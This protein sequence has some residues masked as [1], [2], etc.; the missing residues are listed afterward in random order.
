MLNYEPT[1]TLDV[2]T[3]LAFPIGKYDDDKLVNMGLNRWFG[4]IAFPFKYHLGSFSPGYMTS[5]EIIPSVWLF[6]ENDDF[7]GRKLENDPMVQLEGH[8]THDFTPNFYGSLDML[9]RGGFQS[10]IDDVEVGHAIDIGN[11]GFTVNYQATDNLAIRAGYSTNLF[12]D[13]ELDNSLF[14]VQFVYAWHKASE[15]MKKLMS[16]H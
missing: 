5:I 2:A 7:I 16:G 3:M 4:R 15:N 10:E 1:W 14:R 13:H 11:L 8:V 6:D 12:G 9:Y